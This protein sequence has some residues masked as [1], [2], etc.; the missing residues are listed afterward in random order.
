V[1]ASGR[2][3]LSQE[4]RSALVRAATL[5]P[6]FDLVTEGADRPV[7]ELYESGLGTL[8]SDMSTRLGGVEDRVAASTLHLG[9]VARL[10]SPVLACALHGVVPD[11]TDLRYRTVDGGFRLPEPRGWTASDP[12]PLVYEQVVTG[13]LAPLAE[14]IRSEVKMAEGLLW[15]NAAAALIGALVVTTTG[16]PGLAGPARELAERLLSTGALAGT[17]SFTGPGLAIRR[18]SCCLYYLA[19]GG[20]LC[21]DCSLRRRS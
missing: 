17:V 12:A 13:H 10:W 15:G 14:A 9:L 2:P 3:A 19:P 6:F 1:R 5:G 8:I 21:G 4:V 20:G 11:L 16:H 18:N 7:T